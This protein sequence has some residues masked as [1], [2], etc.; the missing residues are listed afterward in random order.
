MISRNGSLSRES[1]MTSGR[2]WAPRPTILNFGGLWA[3]AEVAPSAMKPPSSSIAD[4][5]PVAV[6]NTVSTVS[7]LLVKTAP[8]PSEL[9]HNR[10]TKKRLNTKN[11]T[12]IAT[13]NAAS[14]SVPLFIG[15]HSPS[16]RS[17]GI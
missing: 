3:A 11:V 17:P 2:P 4:E 15:E 13:I 5:S 16:D 7:Q 12:K 1:S 8:N 14:T 6:T 10:S 9:N